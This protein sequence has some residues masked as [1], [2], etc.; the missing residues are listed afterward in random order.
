MSFSNVPRLFALLSLFVSF[1]VNAT[2]AECLQHQCMAVVDAGSSGSRVHIYSYDLD[3][4]KTPTNIQEL[5]SKKIKPGLA[6]LEPNQAIL[7]PYLSTLFSEAPAENMPVYFYATAGMRMLSQPKQAKIYEVVKNWFANQSSWQ[8]KSSK[9]L[10][11]TEEGLFAWLRINYQLGTLDSDTKPAIGVMDMGGASVQVM[12]PVEKTEGLNDSDLFKLDIYGREKKLFIHSF[13]GLGQDEVA[14]QYLD[15]ASCFA[16]EYELPSGRA[17]A[18]D[19]FNCKDEVS[20]LVNDVHR[21]D[22]TV[23]PAIEANPVNNWFIIGGMAE[24]A[25]TAP[26]QFKNQLTNEAMLEQANSLVCQQQWSKISAEYPSNEFLYGS[27]LFPA[28]YYALMV[29]GYGIKAN[30]KLN[31]LTASQGGDWTLGVVLNQKA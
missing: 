18:G 1:T 14:H 29:E 12:F 2:Q 3:K 11:G 21:V 17:A 24:N 4:S 15:V 13:L 23:Q 16:N 22:S 10:K 20:L 26:F 6:T 5:W 7:N 28:Y 8:L 19:A 30:Q 9:T 31:F 27:C 25:K